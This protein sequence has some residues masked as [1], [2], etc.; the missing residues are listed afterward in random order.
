MM[1]V[2]EEIFEFLGTTLNTKIKSFLYYLTT[3]KG[4]SKN[5]TDAYRNDLNG[6]TD[7]LD[8]QE[9]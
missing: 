1:L 5:T 6:F 2:N 8:K 7:F 9:L 3:E 4:S